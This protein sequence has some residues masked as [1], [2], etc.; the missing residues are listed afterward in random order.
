MVLC[1]SLWFL[2]VFCWFFG[3]SWG[4]LL[5]LGGFGG[6][7]GSLCFFVALNGFYWFFGGFWWF[8]VVLG[9]S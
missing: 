8:L 9:G 2:M 3:G 1:G 5:V 4:F 6:F 7:G